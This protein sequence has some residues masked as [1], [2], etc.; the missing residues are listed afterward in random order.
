MGVIFMNMF[1][2][3]QLKNWNINL[4]VFY[5]TGTMLGMAFQWVWFTN[6]NSNGLASVLK[7]CQEIL[8]LNMYFKLLYSVLEIL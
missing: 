1:V 5:V 6:S 3:F 4:L 7:N 8:S 2:L